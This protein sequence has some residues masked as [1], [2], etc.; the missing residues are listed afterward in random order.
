MSKIRERWRE[1]NEKIDREIEEEDTGETSM[2]SIIGIVSFFVVF[3]IM[4]PVL[5]PILII[6]QVFRPGWFLPCK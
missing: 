6:D 2:S 5:G 3:G 4:I 1:L